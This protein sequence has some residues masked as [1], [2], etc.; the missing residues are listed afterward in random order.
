MSERPSL[1]ITGTKLPAVGV[2]SFGNVSYSV[3]VLVDNTGRSPATNVALIPQLA[4]SPGF[5]GSIP[6][7]LAGSVIVKTNLDPCQVKWSRRER[8]IPD[9]PTAKSRKR[10]TAE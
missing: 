8:G 3:D 9:Q 5:T 7:T 6:A 2:N 1:V 10:G 4:V